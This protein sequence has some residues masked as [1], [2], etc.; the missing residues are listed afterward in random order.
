MTYKLGRIG[1]GHL[2]IA[3]LA[4]LWLAGAP[5]LTP[6][7]AAEVTC[8]NCTPPTGIMGYRWF[9]T[10]NSNSF[11]CQTAGQTITQSYYSAQVGFRT[12]GTIGAIRFSNMLPGG[13]LVTSEILIAGST[14]CA[15]PF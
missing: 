6:A 8:T 3:M 15:V 4:A 7:Q 9:T 13:A 12:D 2:A 10:R 14:T 11:T 5:G 1:P